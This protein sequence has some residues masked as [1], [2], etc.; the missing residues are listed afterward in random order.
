MK[1]IDFYAG[2]GGWSV[3]FKLAGI[4][5]VKSY[6]WW[7][8]AAK[9]H[10]ANCGSDVVVTDIRKLDPGELPKD[11]DVVIGSPP[12]TQFSY[13]NRGGSGDVADG[14]V[15]IAKFLEIV[16]Y[17][18]PRLWAFENVPRV[19]RILEH[20]LQQGG[21]LEKYI[22]LF[23]DAYIEIFDMEDYGVPQRRKRC[24][25][26]NFDFSLLRTYA[27]WTAKPN[28]GDVI[29]ALADSRDPIFHSQGCLSVHDNQSE[30]A[31]SWE[32]E[33]FNRDMKTAHPIYNDMPF[34]DPLDRSSRT[35]TATCTRVSRESLIVED[36]Q[37]KRFRRLSVRERASLQSFPVS[38]QFLGR[39]HAEKLKMVGNAIPPVFTY[40]IAEAMKG[41]TP[42]A[43]VPPKDLDANA[44]FAHMKPVE[45]N[46]DSSGR[47]YP[48]G[49]RFRFSIPHLRFKSGTRFEL[50]NI[51][52]P[53]DWM[54]AFYFGDSKRIHRR[55]FTK[56]LA[57]HAAS[58]ISTTFGETVA[59]SLERLTT[60]ISAL[61]LP[62]LQQ[63]WSHRASGLHPFHLIDKLGSLAQTMEEQL[64]EASLEEI[65][66]KEYIHALIYRSGTPEGLAEKKISRYLFP[67][68]AG[69]LVAAATNQ[70][71]FASAK[72]TADNLALLE[73]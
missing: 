1:A 27:A 31:L 69:T 8:P 51:D 62:S 44:Y 4:D 56:T 20:E 61:D 23:E 17:L 50:S 55:N 54:V 3:G 28:L 15:D 58:G 29:T 65:D 39:S 10:R 37:T 52:G 49:R 53:E 12:C 5:V 30:E 26:G 60:E 21:A 34:P 9:T 43:L 64:R 33:R 16:R 73:D 35:V 45:T 67:I 63:T 48:A 40:L 59:D 6:E 11:I 72:R 41:T 25:A 57:M 32:E 70:A 68:M 22:D 38:F 46:P 71:F 2:V 42:E 7:E 19:K 36:M 18:K 47:T 14:L 66:V 13:S 24:I